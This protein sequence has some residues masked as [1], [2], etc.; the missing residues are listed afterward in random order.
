MKKV[1]TFAAVALMMAG[2]MVY[3]D[4]KKEEKK[5]C[6]PKEACKNEDKK[7]CEAACKKECAAEK[8]ECSAEKKGC[9]TQAGAKKACAGKT[10]PAK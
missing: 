10:C 5:A 6:C 9:A 7:A 3:A 4:A 2:S 8:K 1:M